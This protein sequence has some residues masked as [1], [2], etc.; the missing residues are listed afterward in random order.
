MK[1]CCQRN[2]YQPSTSP[3]PRKRDASRKEF[4]RRALAGDNMW[5]S[6]S[7]LLTLVE[8]FD[9]NNPE[10]GTE[11]VAR[12]IHHKTVQHYLVNIVKQQV[13]RGG[14][15]QTERHEIETAWNQ[16]TFLI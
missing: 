10:M 9:K 7:C 12:Q 1:S 16:T 8:S 11:S 4:G 2:S 13:A 15:S 14:L 5:E 3:D 6:L